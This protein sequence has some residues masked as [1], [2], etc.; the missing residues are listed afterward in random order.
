MK[1]RQEI[2]E[3][4]LELA[5]LQL[6]KG[7]PMS[8]KHKTD[9]TQETFS[10]VP[11]QSHQSSQNSVASTQPPA[12]A[13]SSIPPNP[14]HQN[15]FPTHT[16][17]APQL[18]TQSPNETI[19]SI[20]QHESYRPSPVLIPEVTNEQYH[21]PPPSVV[22]Q[23]N[24]QTR[25]QTTHMQYNVASAAPLHQPYQ[26]ATPQLLPVS[27]S[28]LPPQLHPQYTQAHNPL[29]YQPEQVSYVPSH[30]IRNSFQPP[31][32]FP[33]PQQFHSH[34]P[35]RPH[36]E[37]LSG[38]PPSSDHYKAN[39]SSNMKPLQTSQPPSALGG[40]SSYSKLP[41]VKVLPHAL[42]T[43]SS[44]DSASTAAEGSA[45]KVPVDVVVDKVA[46]MGFRRDLVRATVKKLTENGQTVDLNAVLDKLMNG[47]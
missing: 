40:G 7:D 30:S 25:P 16:A 39:Y 14:H 22:C 17:T 33:Q 37:F 2:A 23:P 20:P 21:Q 4:Q 41:T 18:T 45:N 10:C 3:A 29:N 44:E 5:K 19:S 27:Q 42:P 34:P 36:S 9:S 26:P 28:T 24:Q 47:G 11:Q 32:G 15:P 1:D 35:S 13:L 46:A 8:G 12:A 31:G 38:Y 43:A 6:S